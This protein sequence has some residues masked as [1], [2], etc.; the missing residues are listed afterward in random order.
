MAMGSGGTFDLGQLVLT[1]RDALEYVTIAAALVILV[2]GF[3]D[4]VIDLY[5]W[6]RRAARAVLI[7][8]RFPPLP[9][10]RLM[11]KPESP[12]AIMVP[13]WHEA[14]VI[15]SMLTTN[16]ELVRYRN[17]HFFVGVYAN[18]PATA[19][20]VAK[21]A[22]L[23]P[24]VHT[25]TVPHDGP[26]NKADCLNAVIAGIGRYEREHGFEFV[27]IAMHDAEDVIHPLELKFFNYLIERKDLIQLPIYSLRCRPGALVAGTYMDEFAEWHTKDLVVRES[28]TRTVP[29]AG[30]AACFSRRA[31]QALIAETGEAFNT[32]TLTEDYDIAFRL[33]KLGMKEV[34][35]RFPVAYSVDTRRGGGLEIVDRKAPI[36]TR[37]FFPSAFVASYRQ[38]ARWILGIAFHGWMTMGWRGPLSA[39]YF[40]LRDRKTLITSPVNLVAIFVLVN[41]VAVEIALRL[42]P[43]VPRTPTIFET[44]PAVQALLLANLFFLANRLFHRIYFTTMIYGALHGVIAVPRLLVSNLIN[45][46]AAMRAMAVF[47]DSRLTGRKIVWDKTQHH[48]PGGSSVAG[49][50]APSAPSAAA[51]PEHRPVAARTAG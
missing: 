47:A 24:N 19:A 43:G 30:V 50:N 45:F 7:R 51:Q 20:E 21:V 17:Y 42:M 26:T 49:N 31:I 27:G 38:R 41:F 28:F 39:K 12:I 37:E 10:E 4:L 23:H 13:A 48:F 22:A 5:Y 3:D 29:C 40:L 11:E 8:V 9:V 15:A 2:F 25:V 33:K 6:I 46:F 36:A 35:V 14:D 32:G 18:D 44:S 16:L 1:Y 34:F